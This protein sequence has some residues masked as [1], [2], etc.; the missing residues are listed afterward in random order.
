MNPEIKPY[1]EREQKYI[2]ENA[3]VIS[4]SEIAH[5]LNKLYLE[6]NN[7]NRTRS[8]VISWNSQDKNPL[9]RRQVSIPK[10]LYDKV[11]DIDL[12]EFICKGLKKIKPD[13]ITQ[14]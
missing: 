12:S 7:G 10:D 6:D 4:W 9:I 13:Q 1:S 5:N 11:K 14:E 3:G 2:R 8:G